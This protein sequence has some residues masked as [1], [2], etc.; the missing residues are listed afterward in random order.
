MHPIFIRQFPLGIRKSAEAD[1]VF[2]RQPDIDLVRLLQDADFFARS[3]LL[4][5]RSLAR[6]P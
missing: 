6:R 1:Q 4:Q 3:L 5:A 2:N